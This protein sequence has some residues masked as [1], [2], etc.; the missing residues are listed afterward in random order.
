ML[1]ILEGIKPR[2]IFLQTKFDK[3]PFQFQKDIDSNLSSTSN[4]DKENSEMKETGELEKT[5]KKSNNNMNFEKYLMNRQI[6]YLKIQFVS[7]F[8]M[9][10]SLFLKFITPSNYKMF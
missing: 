2:N 8:S 6:K 4:L 3:Y 5:K 7:K 9:K 1:E 10:I